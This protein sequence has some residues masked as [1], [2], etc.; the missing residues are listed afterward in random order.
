MR[1]LVSPLLLYNSKKLL[2]FTKA[3]YHLN[4]SPKWRSFLNLFCP[5]H[6]L[7]IPLR[8]I[9]NMVNRK[10]NT[11]FIVWHSDKWP[12]VYR[13]YKNSGA[14]QLCNSRAPRS[15]CGVRRYVMLS[16]SCFSSLITSWQR[17]NVR[18][19]EQI[20]NDIENLSYQKIKKIVIRCQK[21]ICA[22]INN[23]LIFLSGLR[24]KYQ[25]ISAL[26]PTWD[27]MQ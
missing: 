12:I 19:Y 23:Y 4:I 17:C 11:F 26:C 16:F 8:P 7:F 18:K 5:K 20:K 27:Q 22:L 3:F 24:T 15:A 1:Y 6:H 10:K 14:H 13:E 2:C 21:L 25:K 9:N